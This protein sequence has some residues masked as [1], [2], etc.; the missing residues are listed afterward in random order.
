[1]VRQRVVKFGSATPLAGVLA[2]PPSGVAKQ[3]VAVILLNSGILHHV[4]ANRLHVQLAHRLAA[5]GFASFRFDLSGI[6][7][8]E[9]RR[10][11]LSFEQSSPLETRDAIDYLERAHGVR[12]VVLMGLCSGAD[13]AHLTALDDARVVGLG[14]LDAWAY[15]TPGYFIH[16]YLRRL[17]SPTAYRNWIQ[18]RWA[19]LVGKLRANSRAM[20]PDSDMYEI[21]RYVR[22]FPPRDQ[23]ARELR[24]FMYRNVKL[25]VIFSGGLE[26]YNHR[27]QY[28]AAFR[29]VD[30]GAR[31]REEHV[32]EAEH[33][34]T[35]LDH[36]EFVVRELSDWVQSHFREP[37]LL[38]PD[39][40]RSSGARIA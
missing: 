6:G 35:R 37:A 24:A 11:E 27:G 25:C 23:V 12:R 32:P 5:A 14:L 9:A 2:E 19:R 13:V 22:V 39:D 4:G 34:F 3:P 1:M 28:A 33:V 20:A 26:E 15:K 17:K 18:V 31:L 36:Q 29:D 8:S 21:P 40:T 7:D 38:R 30:F 16:H 10:D